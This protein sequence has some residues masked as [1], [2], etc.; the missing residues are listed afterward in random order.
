[1]LRPATR[2]RLRTL[3]IPFL[4]S[5]HTQEIGLPHLEYG[6]MLLQKE[7]KDRNIK[8]LCLWTR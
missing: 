6:S 8:P 7:Q 1:V 2:S 3:R 5:Y 4:G